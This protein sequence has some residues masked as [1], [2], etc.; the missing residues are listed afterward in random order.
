MLTQ[1]QNQIIYLMF[2]NGLLFLG[3]NFIAYSII[4][5]GPKGS[6]RK[7]YMLITC[8]L[9]AYLVQQLH[10]GM[11]VLDYPQEN[12]SSLI[13]SG[14]V[15]PVFFISLFYYRIKRNRMEKEQQPEIP[16]KND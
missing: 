5:P 9:M 10:Q 16:E 8:V 12:L 14:F 11:I 4:F 3:L 2:L 15:I 6:K 1:V 7:G 13:L